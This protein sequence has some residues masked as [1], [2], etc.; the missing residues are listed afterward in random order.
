MT[1]EQRRQLRR[2]VLYIIFLTVL[3]LLLLAGVTT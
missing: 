1:R 2:G 3:S